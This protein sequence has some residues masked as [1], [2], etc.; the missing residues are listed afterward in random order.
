MMAHTQNDDFMLEN[1]L[2]G[3]VKLIKNS[4]FDKYKY[5]GNGIGLNVR[6]SLSL[7]IGSG[8]GSG[9][10]H[11]ENK[12]DILILCEGPVQG[13]DDTILPAEKE[14]VVNLVKHRTNFL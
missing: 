14:D 3:A 5:S 13:L 7:S 10:A 4:F 11:V 9:S 1:V 2:F 12:K 6:E 8:F